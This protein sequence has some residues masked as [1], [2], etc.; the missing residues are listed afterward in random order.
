MNVNFNT[1][2][3]F[4]LKHALVNNEPRNLYNLVFHYGRHAGYLIEFRQ[5]KWL[6]TVFGH[7]V[8]YSNQ[9][10]INIQNAPALGFILD[11]LAVEMQKVLVEIH[12]KEW[13]PGY[14][15]KMLNQF[16]LLD[17]FQ[18]ADREFSKAFF[19]KSVGVRLLHIGLALYYLEHGMTTF[20]E[21]IARDTLQDLE[22]MGEDLY[23]QTLRMIFGRLKMSGPTFWED[24]DRGN[25]N[26][27]YS[28]HSDQIESFKKL[29]ERFLNE[30]SVLQGA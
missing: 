14:Q 28:P 15:Q 1:S 9:C 26:I 7:Y 22:L 29:Q 18:S 17:N 3:R 21:Q 11:V 12:Q 30:E 19:S 25:L 23:Q 4:A 13:N 27:Y 8:F 16:L 20:A 24:T 5:H 6:Q 2:F 10:F